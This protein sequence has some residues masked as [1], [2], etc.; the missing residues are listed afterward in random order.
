VGTDRG[1]NAVSTFCRSTLNYVRE[2]GPAPREVDIRDGR[3]AGLPGW[4]ECGFELVQ[5]PSEVHDWFD[6]DEVAQVHHAEA[7]ALA[8]QMTGADVALVSSHIKRNPDE[9]RRHQQ[10][11][12]ITFVHSDFA[13]GHDGIIRRTYTAENLGAMAAMARHGVTAADVEGAARIVILQFWRNVGPPKMDFP[14]AFCDARTV[15]VDE[16]IAIHVENYAGTG[17]T[18]DALAVR[19]PADPDAHAWYAFPELEA[20]EA[21]AFRTYDSDRVA[22]GDVWFTPHSAFRDPE[23]EPGRPARASIELRATCAFF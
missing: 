12:P 23:V 7:E 10:L 22:A 1:E 6:G 4:Q 19:A 5:H 17:A 11:S 2:G 16:T 3:T 20:H 18:F 21:V 9:T 8:K 14:L 13:A 15:A